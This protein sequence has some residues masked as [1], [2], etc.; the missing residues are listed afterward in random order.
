MS[1]RDQWSIHI[2]ESLE[3][4][5]KS[6]SQIDQRLESLENPIT[7]RL[8]DRGEAVSSCQYCQATILLETRFCLKCKKTRDE[9]FKKEYYERMGWDYRSPEQKRKDFKIKQVAI[10]S[11]RYSKGDK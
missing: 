7:Q 6:I 1:D 9:F 3:H 4:L 8:E 5:M 11:T 2:S 10:R